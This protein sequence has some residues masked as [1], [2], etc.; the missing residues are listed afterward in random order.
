MRDRR[1]V[2]HSTP[3]NPPIDFE[4][5]ATWPGCLKAALDGDRYQGTLAEDRQADEILS[6]ERLLG[7]HCTRLLPYEAAEIREIGLCPPSP[8]FLAERINRAREAGYL[9]AKLCRRLRDENQAEDA[10]RVGRICFVHRRSC[11]RAESSVHRFFESWGG[12]V[13]YNSHEQDPTTGPTLRSLGE[14]YIVIASLPV[15]KLEGFGYNLSRYFAN[16]LLND[17]TR[18]KAGRPELPETSIAGPVPSKW[19]VELVSFRD[20]SFESL[21]QCH[22]QRWNLC[23]ARDPGTAGRT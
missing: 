16:K 15:N 18:G 21:T 3:S 5:S 8:K 9:P 14:P 12:E 23:A 6:R 2:S 20:A 1:L 19:V 13:L 22:A 17:S 10:N 4:D 11:L 7:F